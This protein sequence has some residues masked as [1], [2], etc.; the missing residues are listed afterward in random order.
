M[1]K[2]NPSESTLMLWLEEALPGWILPVSGIVAALAV[3]ILYVTE[4]VSERTIGMLV[5]VAFAGGLAWGQLIPALQTTAIPFARGI[6]VAGAVFCVGVVLY[7]FQVVGFPGAAA[8]QATLTL[9]QKVLI[10]PGQGAYRL[11]VSGRLSGSGEAKGDYRLTPSGGG[12]IN[13]SLKRSIARMSFKRGTGVAVP[14]EHTQMFHYA[15]VGSPP[16]VELT[17]L[18]TE[19]KGE[20]HVAAFKTLPL[21]FLLAWVAAGLLATSVTDVLVGAKGRCAVVGGAAACF[22]LMM[23]TQVAPD[24]VAK[25]TFGA[26]ML[27]VAAG[28]VWQAIGPRLAK[29]LVP[30]G[31]T[32]AGR[33]KNAAGGKEKRS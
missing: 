5:T 1:A 25:P 9:N 14:V 2:P 20:L 32:K 28:A 8:A 33:A 3:F 4:L 19:L 27:G 17:R 10:L 22:S 6:G 16:Q 26:A 11:L 31:W 23:V 12:E 21:W 15:D 29:A 13:G 7:S 30:E 18:G 24:F